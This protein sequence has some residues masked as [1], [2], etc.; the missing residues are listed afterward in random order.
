LSSRLT[1]IKLIQMGISM[2]LGVGY[3]DLKG[4]VYLKR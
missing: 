1:K 2:K 4:H 3:F